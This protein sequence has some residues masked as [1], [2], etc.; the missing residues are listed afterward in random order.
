MPKLPSS[1]PPHVHIGD[2]FLAVSI[3]ET[4]HNEASAPS[5]LIHDSWPIQSLKVE[6]I[7]GITWE[8]PENTYLRM[9]CR[10]SKVWTRATSYLNVIYLISNLPLFLLLCSPMYEEETALRVYSRVW[11][12]VFI[13]LTSVFSPAPWKDLNFFCSH[14]KRALL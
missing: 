10:N 5:T 3:H 11:Y 7:T 12:K 9:L 8:L 6:Q 13:S 4:A 2:I 1:C 14:R